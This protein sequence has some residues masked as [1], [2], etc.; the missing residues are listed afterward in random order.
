MIA[1]V[2][3]STKRKNMSGYSIN[4]EEATLANDFFRKVLFTA[5]HSQ[6][7]LMTLKP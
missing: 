4:I 1:V 2:S 6:L 3:K 5:P 7:V